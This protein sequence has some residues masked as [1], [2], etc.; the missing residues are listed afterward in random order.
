MH[1]LPDGLMSNIRG[2][3]MI[4]GR[5]KTILV[6]LHSGPLPRRRPLAT[7]GILTCNVYCML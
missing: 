7:T 2:K 3:L 5:G 1:P 4:V 6:S